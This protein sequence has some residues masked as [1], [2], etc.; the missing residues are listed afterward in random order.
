[1]GNN[2]VVPLTPTDPMIDAGAEVLYGHT[3]AQAR[4][5]AK[6]DKFDSRAGEASKVYSAMISAAG[7]PSMAELAEKHIQSRRGPHFL[8]ALE[9]FRNS[10]VIPRSQDL[11]RE[12]W[13]HYVELANPLN[14]WP[15]RSSLYGQAKL[16]SLRKLISIISGEDE[17][18]VQSKATV[19]ALE[20]APGTGLELGANVP[21]PAA[22]SAGQEAVAYVIE[23]VIVGNDGIATGY[24]APELSFYRNTSIG[25]KSRPLIYGDAA[26]L[27]GGERAADAQQLLSEDFV[28]VL[29]ENVL[30]PY[31]ND[32][33]ADASQVSVDIAKKL[34]EGDCV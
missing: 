19:A 13:G 25:D 23:R 6:E 21:T 26:P 15:G 11:D 3:R 31:V 12:L 27:N 17:E 1:M 16:C 5:W 34:N 18:Q 10:G 33:T 30:R 29:H 7:R 2:R 32:R 9:T 4:E 22:R 8:H 28:R 20:A 14:E 24:G